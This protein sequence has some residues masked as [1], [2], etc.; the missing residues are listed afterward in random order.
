M[1]SILTDCATNRLSEVLQANKMF[2]EVPAICCCLTA[3]S[4]D[5][6]GN[7]K[8][9]V[10]MKGDCGLDQQ[11]TDEERRWKIQRECR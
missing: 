10:N 6:T 5:G 3:T 1:V 9:P 8:N 2:L 4:S 11:M 7:Q